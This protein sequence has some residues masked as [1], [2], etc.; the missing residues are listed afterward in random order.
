M[1]IVC[2]YILFKAHCMCTNMCD[3]YVDAVKYRIAG[4]FGVVFN[5]ANWRFCRNS[6]NLKPATIFHTLLHYAE[7]LAIA[8]FKV[9]QCI[10]MTDSP[11]LMLA[12]VSRYTVFG[13]TSVQTELC[14]HFAKIAALCTIYSLF[15]ACMCDDSCRSYLR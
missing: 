3:L 15:I 2:K 11:N 1:T 6:P 12:K 9:C 8:K 5:L 7:A 4:N 14:L 13:N 10:L